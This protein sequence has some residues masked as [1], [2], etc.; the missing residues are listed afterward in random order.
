MSIAPRPAARARAAE[1]ASTVAD[2][3]RFLGAHVS[4]AGGLPRAFERGATLGCTTMQVFVKNASRWVG[5]EL[6]DE[7]VA[8]FRAARAA[9]PCGA[10]P[11]VAHAAYLINLAAPEGEVLTRS[12]AGLADELERCKASL[13]SSQE[14]L[15]HSD[16]GLPPDEADHSPSLQSCRATLELTPDDAGAIALEAAE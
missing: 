4:V 2:T 13:V 10:Q 9:A 14:A 15:D 1:R 5:K 12:R 16:L 3:S 8:A 6:L 11:I 7:E